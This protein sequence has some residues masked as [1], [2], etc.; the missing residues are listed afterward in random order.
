MN[1]LSSL[2][3]FI[4]QKF[5]D[6]QAPEEFELIF[7]DELTY[8]L[9][10]GYGIYDKSS[11]IVRLHFSFSNG[12]RDIPTSTVLFTVPEKYRPSEKKLGTGMLIGVSEGTGS[13][14]IIPG[15]YSLEFGNIRQ[16]RMNRGRLGSGYFEY[17]LD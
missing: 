13:Q 2:L 10:K 11:G 5:Q 4:G 7:N 8:G 9:G 14:L 15:L 3:Y 16:V 12:D 17:K 6:A 1:I